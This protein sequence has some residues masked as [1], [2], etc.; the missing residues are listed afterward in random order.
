[1]VFYQE[2]NENVQFAPIGLVDMYNSGGAIKALNYI[3]N[4]SSQCTVKIKSRGCG[5][6]GA[7]SRTT[8]K[9]CFIDGKREEFDYDAKNGFLIFKLSPCFESE[10]KEIEIV[11]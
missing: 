5:R 10:T 8:P 1:M 2:Y 7:Y 11:Y 9:S 4:D 6:F 3:N